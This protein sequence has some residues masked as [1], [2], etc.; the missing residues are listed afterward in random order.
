MVS[1]R[2]AA[3]E[4]SVWAGSGRSRP[5]GAAGQCSAT[6]PTR[7]LLPKTR[8]FRP[9]G[10]PV[11]PGPISSPASCLAK[12]LYSR[13][14]CRASPVYLGASP[15]PV[16]YKFPSPRPPR[17]LCHLHQILR[18]H[19]RNITG[20]AG[21]GEAD[22]VAKGDGGRGASLPGECCVH[23]QLLL[24][25]TRPVNTIHAGHAHEST[26]QPKVA[27][28]PDERADFCFDKPGSVSRGKS[29][30]RPRYDRKRYGAD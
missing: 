23:G 6:P 27:G 13:P 5:Y 22:R 24:E 30:C 8:I 25:R 15:R 1:D 12:S 18:S 21:D 4:G 29:T 16:V 19:P 17:L 9:R 28:D 26:A 7:P 11:D 10:A 20:P 14:Y 2:P 3:G